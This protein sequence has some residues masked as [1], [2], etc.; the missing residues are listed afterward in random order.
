MREEIIRQ[1]SL[2]TKEEEEI[3]QGQKLNKKRY[4]SRDEF[5]ID[6]KKMLEMG[7]L[8]DIRPHT[9]FSAF[10]KHTHNYVEIIYM[11]KGT[12]RHHVQDSVTIDL[13]EGDL[14]FLNQYACHS[15]EAAGIEDLAINFIVLP[16]FFDTAFTMLDEENE[17]K[18]F[19]TD[20]LTRDTGRASYL[21]FKVGNDLPVQNLLENMIW[22]ILSR[23]NNNSGKINQ[24]TMGLLLLHLMSRTDMLQ[25][26]DKSQ[27]ESRIAMEVLQYIEENYREASLNWI[28]KQEQM[29]IYQ[30]S[31][32][33]RKQTGYTF[34]ELLQ[35]KR[36]NKAAQLL[37]QTNL[38]VADIIAAVGYD[39]TSYF[40]RVFRARYQLS[41]REYR[42][43][44]RK[45]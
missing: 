30:L 43:K 11:L 16:E 19:L 39:N 40:F 15:I 4:T 17:L 14:L 32:T 42:L 23:R 24:I 9:R 22:T 20:T 25:N 3:L 34:K 26:H 5:V 31:R 2:I 18:H 41:P 1:L 21:H 45:G 6:S 37:C 7:Q 28:A 29:S 10:P 8:I 38:P 33:I 12:T 27:H 44:N 13:E 35:I 36:L